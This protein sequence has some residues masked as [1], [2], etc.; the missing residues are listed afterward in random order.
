MK[1]ILR[2]IKIEFLFLLARV[3]KKIIRYKDDHD[4]EDIYPMW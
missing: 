3:F 4:N 2:K 1:K